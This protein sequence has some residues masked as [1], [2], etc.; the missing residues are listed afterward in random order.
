MLME[1]DDDERKGRWFVD[2]VGCF[3]WTDERIEWV[4]FFFWLI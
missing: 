1:N 4:G 3:T 2:Y